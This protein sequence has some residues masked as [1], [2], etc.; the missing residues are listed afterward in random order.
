MFRNE[1]IS[2]CKDDNAN[3]RKLIPCCV[4][5]RHHCRHNHPTCLKLHFRERKI[6]VHFWHE[7]KKAVYSR[8]YKLVEPTHCECS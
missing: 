2:A 5:K 1:L 8:F 6:R 3:C 4:P 7:K